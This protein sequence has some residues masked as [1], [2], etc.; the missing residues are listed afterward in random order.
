MKRYSIV[1]LTITLLLGFIVGFLFYLMLWTMTLVGYSA[2]LLFLLPLLLMIYT[3]YAFTRAQAA[4]KIKYGGDEDVNKRKS[5]VHDL[6]RLDYI[7]KKQKIILAI[8]TVIMVLIILINPPVA[9]EVKY[10][11]HYRIYIGVNNS[12]SYEVITSIPIDQNGVPLFNVDNYQEINGNVSSITVTETEHGKGLTIKGKNNV[13]IIY[14][15]DKC[16]RTFSMLES[17]NRYSFWQYSNSNEIMLVLGYQSFYG[18]YYDH[19][20][21]NRELKSGTVC[22]LM[23]LIYLNQSWHTYSVYYSCVAFN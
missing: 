18:N 15:G 7:K 4:M 21:G 22:T 16:E 14:S 23:T 9:G 2:I 8:V 5:G 12:S 3:T 10:N 6:K 20:Y 13:T 11:F 1:F 19:L 17:N